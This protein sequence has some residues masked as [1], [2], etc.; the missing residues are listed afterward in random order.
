MILQ[1]SLIEGR[2][3]EM[4]HSAKSFEPWV[5]WRP[6]E[7]ATVE[8]AFSRM[9]ARLPVLFG[10]SAL[11]SA[12]DSTLPF[13][14]EHELVELVINRQH[15]ATNVY[16]LHG[17]RRTGWLAG[18]SAP[19]HAI[20]NFESLELTDATAESYLRFFLCFLQADD[21]FFE[22]TESAEEF[23]DVPGDSPEVMAKRAA[24]R[25]ALLPL[26][27]E[28]VEDERWIFRGTVAYQG[29]LYGARFSVDRI[30]EVTMEDDEP[31]VTS[32]PQL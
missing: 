15:N 31:L 21:G 17:D 20:N 22:L 13:Y 24:L 32:R 19:I 9:K 29:W 14:R 1:L 30:G 8:L 25:E 6:C 26:R 4:A 7:P 3:Y 23:P 2:A 28:G 5:A 12:R 16:L 18:T 11:I 10:S 27:G